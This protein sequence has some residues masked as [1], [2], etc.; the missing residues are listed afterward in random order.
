VHISGVTGET[1]ES[2]ARL[3]K[4]L[5]EG[6]ATILEAWGR[7]VQELPAAKRL[8]PVA[9]RRGMPALLGEIERSVETGLA[10][11]VPDQ[12]IQSHALARLAEGFDPSQL[13]TEFTLMRGCISGMLEWPGA[14]GDIADRHTLDRAIDQAAISCL[15]H[16]TRAREE[17][18][19]RSE[20]NQELQRASLDILFSSAPDAIGVVDRELRY[21]RVNPALAAINGRT[22]EEH[23]G[24]TIGEIL[25]SAVG[26]TISEFVRSTLRDGQP[27]IVELS[28]ESLNPSRR[29]S[30][31]RMT[32]FPVPGRDG[33][34]SG[35][36]AV[37][38]NITDQKRATQE[39]SLFAEASSLLNSSPDASTVLERLAR[40]IVQY[41]ADACVIDM[42]A[43]Y[44]RFRR[45]SE[46][47][48]A[49]TQALLA[50]QLALVP[51]ALVLPPVKL[52]METGRAQLL[53][54]LTSADLEDASLG[55]EHR[56]AIE[57]FGPTSAML[58][59]LR[60][61]TRVVGV[62]SIFSRSGEFHLGEHDLR[63]AQELA[64]RAGM[65]VENMRLFEE[66]QRSA[67]LRE[68]VLTTV[69]HD[70]KNPLTAVGLGA[71]TL[72]ASRV[73]EAE[74]P[75]VQRALGLID[76]SCQHMLR[77]IEDLLDVGSIQAGQLAIK[78]SQHDIDAL[79]AEAVELHAA[80]AVERQIDL[81]RQ[82]EA[83][84]VVVTCDRERI[85]QV[86][87]N[88]IGNALKFSPSG[89]R[90]TLGA[91]LAGNQLI[92]SV[93]DTGPGIPQQDLPHIFEPYWTGRRT[94]AKGTGLGLFISKGIIEAHGGQMQ[95][96]TTA[97]S[98]TRFSFG[99]PIAAS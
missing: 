69:C 94:T 72:R 74:R 59:P 89:A 83:T 6:E 65:A 2:G 1:A 91:G 41:L 8:D 3:A 70:L 85:L 22:V 95:V 61:G 13:M 60:A 97:G 81:R 80:M 5:R 18:F 75:K 71:G 76:R 24:K 78:R 28:D 51:A 57:R 92:C 58:V 29:P 68:R 33:V 7:A 21:V 45:V 43:H 34:V 17:Q 88:L 4:F 54:E 55:A 12:V 25:P 36:G 26:E 56:A 52:V 37:I 49:A 31:F 90:I 35:V 23:L 63:I 77:L 73:D 39:A 47:C 79:L 38:V 46:S 14:G 32:Y 42:P 82:G 67:Q 66:A 30:Y 19:Q 10:E 44:G 87:A 93:S 86:F 40:L 27:K 53:S 62:A 84:G 11:A 98:G 48:D 99:L 64:D 20:K 15:Q 96:T 16:Y 9:V 50:A